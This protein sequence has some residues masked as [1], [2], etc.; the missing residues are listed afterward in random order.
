MLAQA[1]GLIADGGMG[2]RDLVGVSVANAV[3]PSALSSRHDPA[4]DPAR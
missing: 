1:K 2:V 4:V 3:P